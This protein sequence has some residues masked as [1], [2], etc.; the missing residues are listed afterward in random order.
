LKDLS[1]IDSRLEDVSREIDGYDELSRMSYASVDG[2]IVTLEDRMYR[3]STYAAAVYNRVNEDLE[4]LLR[5]RVQTEKSLLTG[6]V[7]ILRS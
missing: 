5:E 1:K 3:H 4:L 2:E 7:C 6:A